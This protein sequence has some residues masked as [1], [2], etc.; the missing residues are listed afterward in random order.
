MVAAAAIFIGLAGCD[1]ANPY[2]TAKVNSVGPGKVCI[3]PE[4]RQQ[5]DWAGCYTVSVKDAVLLRA[6]MCVGLRLPNPADK[7]RRDEQVRELTVL[8]RTCKTHG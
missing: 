2:T 4:D 5:A 6:G 7:T 1:T 8:K 3:T